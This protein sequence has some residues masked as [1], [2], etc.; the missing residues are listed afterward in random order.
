MGEPTS[1]LPDAAPA[2]ALASILYVSKASRPVTTADLVRILVG[3]RRRNLIED[4]TG[5]LLYADGS[6]MQYL[7]G[8]PAGLSRVYHVI[9]ADPLHFGLVDLLRQPV[10]HREFGEWSMACHIVGADGDTALCDRYALLCERLA[11]ALRPRSQAAELLSR[12]WSHGRAS[13]ARVL[14]ASEGP[15]AG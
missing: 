10:A 7:E 12:F 2:T 15:V 3:A 8:P 5:V 1:P 6:F 14:E 13:V 9:K 11:H 4:V